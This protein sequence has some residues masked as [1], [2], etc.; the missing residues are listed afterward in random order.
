MKTR[1]ILLGSL[2]L[3]GLI[4]ISQEKP[5]KVVQDTVTVERQ[6]DSI[7]VKQMAAQVKLDSIIKAKKK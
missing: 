4:A 5:K 1:T 7:Y 2:L 3:L 6:P